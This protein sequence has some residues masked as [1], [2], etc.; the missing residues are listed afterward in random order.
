MGSNYDISTYTRDGCVVDYAKLPLDVAWGE[1][2][3]NPT[4]I[5]E[6]KRISLPVWKKEPPAPVASGQSAVAGVP[7]A[8]APPPSA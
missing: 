1:D 8:K 4:A 5:Q 2:T 7:E 3:L 6:S